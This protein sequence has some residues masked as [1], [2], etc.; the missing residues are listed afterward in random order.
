M[1]IINLGSMLSCTINDNGM[2]KRK[3]KLI[4]SN[5]MEILND[6]ALQFKLN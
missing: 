6:I 2:M 1:S 5:G 4:S 3:W